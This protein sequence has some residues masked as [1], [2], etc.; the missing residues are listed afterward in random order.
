MTNEFKMLMTPDTDRP[1]DGAARVFLFI[2]AQRGM[3]WMQ[4]VVTRWRIVAHSL[5]IDRF[6]VT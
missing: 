6:P 4:E 3:V 2:A 5:V 1:I